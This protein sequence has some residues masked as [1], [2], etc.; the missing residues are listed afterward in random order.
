MKLPS[1]LLPGAAT[2]VT[3]LFADLPA[4]N[5]AT[6]VNPAHALSVQ[7]LVNPPAGDGSDRGGCTGQITLDDVRFV[8]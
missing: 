5:P 8:P 2:D 1:T 3:V 6:V 7:W 4:G